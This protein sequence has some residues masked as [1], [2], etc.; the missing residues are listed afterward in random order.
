[1][2]REELSMQN[3]PHTPSASMSNLYIAPQLLPVCCICG[4]IRD[5]TGC[6]PQ[7]GPWVTP[8]TYQKIHGGNLA[9][10]SLTHTYC[11]K[12]LVKVQKTVRQYLREGGT[13]R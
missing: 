4:F 1:M 8:R 9:D 13:T 6:R 3:A 11:P 10:F 5:E 12:C 2:S 7:H